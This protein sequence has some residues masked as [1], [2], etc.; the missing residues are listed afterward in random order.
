MHRRKGFTL[1]ELLVVIS[2]IALLIGI[3]L[4]AL[5]AARATARRMQSNTQLRGI[6]QGMVMFA[7]GNNEYY[8]GMRSSGRPIPAQVN[9]DPP[10]EKERLWDNGYISEELRDSDWRGGGDPSVRFALM[11]EGDYFSG[12]YMVS[13]SEAREEFPDN[14]YVDELNDDSPELAYSYAMLEIHR[15]YNDDDWRNHRRTEWAETMNTRAPVLSDRAQPRGNPPQPRRPQQHLQHSHT[16][17]QRRLA[18]RRA[19]ERQPRQL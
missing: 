6:H 15:G 16:P 3:L 11:L 9:G 10:V 14:I 7:Q 12:D 17:E 18:R 19:L 1:I 4:P 2:I 5:A 13:P 8:P